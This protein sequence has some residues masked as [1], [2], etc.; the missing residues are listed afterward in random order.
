[1]IMKNFVLDPRLEQDTIQLGKL[2]GQILLLMNNALAPWFILVPLTDKH[3]IYLLDDAEQRTLL[4]NLNILS[5]HLLQHFEID[6]INIGAI[7]NIVS[8]LHIHIVGRSTTD[9]AWP[10][11]V[12][13]HQNQRS[14]HDGEIDLIVENLVSDHEVTTYIPHARFQNQSHVDE[15]CSINNKIPKQSG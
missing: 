13:G 6:K 7:G 10:S 5:K 9:D 8:Q 14:Y 15:A 4:N 3:E 11:V 2:N 1:M 12:W